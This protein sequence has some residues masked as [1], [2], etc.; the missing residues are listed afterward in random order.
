M[1]LVERRAQLVTNINGVQN[2][3]AR[4]ATLLQRMMGAI[5][6]IDEL[7]RDVPDKLPTDEPV[8]FPKLEE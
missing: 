4:L 2:E 8:D 5:Q 7:L 6:L 3:Q 1:T